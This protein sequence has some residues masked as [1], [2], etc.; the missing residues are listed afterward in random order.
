TAG[1]S[2]SASYVFHQV[3]EKTERAPI[4]SASSPSF[5]TRL[6]TMTS[7]SGSLS[8]SPTRSSWAFTGHL[9]GGRRRAAAPTR[10]PHARPPPRRRGGAPATRR[11]PRARH[12]PG[13][14]LGTPIRPVLQHQRA[15]PLVDLRP[16]VQLS[17]TPGA[18]QIYAGGA[19]AA[20]GLNSDPAA[21]VT[22]PPDVALLRHS[23]RWPL[24]LEG[25]IGVIR[26]LH[27]LAAGVDHDPARVNL[28]DPRVQQGQM[29]HL[30]GQEVR[31]AGRHR[32]VTSSAASSA[33]S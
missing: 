3:P 25:D 8:T 20:G 10:R 31:L 2:S 16:V 21:A 27:P 30:A 19:A 23:G 26:D 33:R 12:D 32:A 9:R 4:R 11:P 28:D 13:R 5:G 22:V 24:P 7:R 18:H 6:V 17:I 14:S 15:T 29:H 1:T